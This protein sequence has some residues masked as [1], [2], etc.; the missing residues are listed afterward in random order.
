VRYRSGLEPRILPIAGLVG[1]P[2]L[3]A[4]DI[5]I[6]FGVYDRVSPVAALAF[7]T[8]AVWELSLGIWLVTKGFKPAAVAALTSTH[9]DSELSPP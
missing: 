4:S 7:I 2:L 6:S 5:A 3:L 1:A 9:P 8:I